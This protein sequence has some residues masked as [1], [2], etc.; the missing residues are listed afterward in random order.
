MSVNLCWDDDAKSIVRCCF[1][2]YWTWEDFDAS[3]RKIDMMRREVDYPIH[4]VLDLSRT[5]YVPQSTLEY[6][7]E[8]ARRHV[9]NTGLNII[10]SRHPLI[11]RLYIIAK[12]LY[13]GFESSFQL[14]SSFDK[15]C[16]I[17]EELREM[18]D[19]IALTSFASR[20]LLP[21]C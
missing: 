16:D 7:Q 6:L 13:F 9:P 17:I 21:E 10:V 1:E 18:V 5:T 12:R 3:Y 2:G 19:T 11:S 15:A 8:F 20:E 14:V 4:M